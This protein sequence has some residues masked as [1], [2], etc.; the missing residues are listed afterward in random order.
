MNAE[1]PTILVVDDEV[2]SLETLRRTLEED[3]R[4]LTAPGAEEA[5]RILEGDFV[6][7][8]LSDQRMPGM[9]GVEFLKGVRER[10][11]D[12]VRIIISGYTDPN[13]LIAAVNDAGIYQFIHKPWR[14]EALLLTVKGAARLFQLQRDN[15]LLNIELKAAEPVFHGRVQAK[16]ERLRQRFGDQ[17][18]VRAANSPLNAICEMTW[19]VAAHDIPVLITGESGTGKELVARA[20]HYRS[21]RWDKP[22][23]VE[24]CAALPEQLLESELF[25]HKRGS[26][27]GAYEDRVGLF[28]QAD[29][30]T[31]F[32]DE[33]GDTSPGFQVKLLRVLQEGEIRPVGAARPVKIDVRVISATNRDLEDDVRQGHFREDLYYRLSTLS[34]HLPPL[35]ERPMDI[36]LVAESLFKDI[37][38][39][40]GKP[41]L[42]FTDAAMRCLREY[43]W[44]GN[45]RQLQNEILRMAALADD[46]G[47]L[48]AELLSPRV[49]RGGREDEEA[50]LSLLAGLD[51]SLKER[52]EKLE[53]KLVKE[54]LIRHR[55]NKSRAAEE[56]GLSRV[57]LRGKLARYGLEGED[58]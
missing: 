37:A 9:S 31:I 11:P 48:G 22:F 55:W 20:I 27:T 25:G 56:L 39:S 26:F 52:M 50:E 43:H 10:W 45:V 3:F 4:V 35:R 51:G 53:A 21:P 34:I 29:G 18:I 12:V 13:D 8:V 16:R 28:Q 15:E 38:Q 23:V 30:G 24:N 17:Q 46:G 1:L 58:K 33:I 7:V 40:L 41:L 42:G 19:K 32:L 57:G 14:P 5:L 2:R 54:V 36:P 47:S 6:Q 44:P 49:L